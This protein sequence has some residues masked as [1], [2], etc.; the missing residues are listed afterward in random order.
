MLL[1][2]M[3]HKPKGMTRALLLERSSRRVLRKAKNP[4]Q[5]LLQTRKSWIQTLS[6]W[7]RQ[8]EG[9][10]PCSRSFF[11]P[12]CLQFAPSALHF[13]TDKQQ[14]FF[15]ILDKTCS[16]R[17]VVLPLIPPREELSPVTA[18]AQQRAPPSAHFTPFHLTNELDPF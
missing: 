8:G 11:C 10:V 3:T 13:N 17:R 7:T 16:A 1:A 18:S 12:F 2:Q 5:P 9:S 4:R 15:Q 6:T 14:P